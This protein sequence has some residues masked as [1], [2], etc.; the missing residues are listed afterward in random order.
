MKRLSALAQLVALYAECKNVTKTA[1]LAKLTGR[2]ER[3]IWYAK[4]EL[5]HASVKDASVSPEVSF[6]EIP[7]PSPP[8]PQ[9]KGSPHTPLKENSPL[10]P[11]SPSALARKTD[12]WQPRFSTAQEPQGEVSF[13]GRQLTLG[14]GER[15]FWLEQFGGDGP[16]L[17]LALV[18]AAGYVQQHSSRPLLVQVRAQLARTAADKRDRDSRYAV[19]AKT[20]GINR[21]PDGAAVSKAIFDRVLG[22]VPS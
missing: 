14:P 21:P 8:A 18:T 19:A 2:T 22:R 5:K 3:Q 7:P 20:N 9:K 16:R 6:T 1:D 11:S 13:D 15:S 17:D 12:D 4:A 10:P